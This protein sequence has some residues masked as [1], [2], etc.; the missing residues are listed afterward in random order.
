MSY[1]SELLTVAHLIWAKWANERIPSPVY[2]CNNNFGV[3][4]ILIWKIKEISSYQCFCLFFR[5]L[6]SRCWGL[7]TSTPFTYVTML[8]FRKFCFRFE[9][10]LIAT[11]SLQRFCMWNKAKREFFVSFQANWSRTEVCQCRILARPCSETKENPISSLGG[12][13]IHQTDETFQKS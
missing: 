5:F 3:N 7:L 6:S 4:W 9:F 2:F 13:V 8:R 11:V 1:L 12:T 10:S